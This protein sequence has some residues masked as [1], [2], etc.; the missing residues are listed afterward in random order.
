M[1]PLWRDL[2]HYSPVFLEIAVHGSSPESFTGDPLY[3][4]DSFG[5]S[6]LHVRV[7]MVTHGSAAATGIRIGTN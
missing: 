1:N 7:M 4:P 3:L 2:R 5:M 6:R